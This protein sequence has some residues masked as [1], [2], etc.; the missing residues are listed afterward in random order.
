M[1]GSPH[2]ALAVIERFGDSGRA[3][4]AEWFVYSSGHKE[5]IIGLLKFW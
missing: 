4:G 5:S 1:S 2:G 3:Q